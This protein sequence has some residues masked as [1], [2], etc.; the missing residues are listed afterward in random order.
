MLIEINRDDGLPILHESRCVV[1]VYVKAFK[2][3]HIH[4]NRMFAY[5]NRRIEIVFTIN[6]PKA[7]I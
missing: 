7:K 4:I 3:W 1:C 6:E 5:V 2:R